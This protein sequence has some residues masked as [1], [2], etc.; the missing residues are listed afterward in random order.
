MVYYVPNFS[1][2]ENKT[3]LKTAPHEPKKPTFFFSQSFIYQIC[4]KSLIV[5]ICE[6][7]K[8]DVKNTGRTLM[9]KDERPEGGYKK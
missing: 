2:T 5:T 4:A 8:I 3:T 6:G 1:P 9:D 7:A